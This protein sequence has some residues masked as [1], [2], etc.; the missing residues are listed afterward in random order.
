MPPDGTHFSKK[1]PV[2]V[3]AMDQR[4]GHACGMLADIYI[5]ALLVEE[6]AADQTWELWSTG[7]ITDDLAALD[8]AIMAFRLRP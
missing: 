6:E 5:E 2:S 3:N 7:V 4:S 8:W 1:R